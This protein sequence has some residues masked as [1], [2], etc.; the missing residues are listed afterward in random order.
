MENAAAEDWEIVAS[1]FPAGWQPQARLSGAVTR[2]RGF[3]SADA[4]LRLILSHVGLGYS[5]REAS[6]RARAEGWAAVSDVTLLNRLRQCEGWLHW[7]CVQL[8]KENRLGMPAAP[9]QRRVRLLDGTVIREPGKTGSQ[10]RMLY[11]F[12]LPELRC[13][14]F[15][16]TAVKG[17]G[18]EESLTRVAVHKRDLLLADAGFC[19]APGI[20][21]AVRRG[22]DVV[23]RVDPQ[24]FAATD[25]RG[26]RVS[27]S[28]WLGQLQRPGEVGHWRVCLPGP[29]GTVEGVVCALRKS[30]HAIER[31]HRRLQ[32]TAA[33]RQTQPTP[34]A[35]EFAKHVVVFSSWAA[36]SVDQVLEWYRVR[37]QFELAF[38]RLRSLA[39]LGH[40]PKHDERSCRAWMYGKLF[41]ALLTQKLLRLGRDVSP[42]GY[43]LAASNDVV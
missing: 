14:Y 22:G 3:S 43:R 15:E 24:N 11:S 28:R 26:R 41:S 18:A 10:W 20:G 33:T 35:W 36:P 13:D 30:Q 29:H 27:L 5:M 4:L 23:V 40:L 2:M 37:W 1:L 6:E 8:W 19:T 9:E 31:A 38:K 7:L 34:E 25:A 42:W 16:L 39:G 21:S 32:R 12:C 17:I